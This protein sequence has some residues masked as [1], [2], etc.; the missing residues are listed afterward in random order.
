MGLD[1]GQERKREGSKGQ[2][3]RFA[4]KI[5]VG[6]WVLATTERGSRMFQMSFDPPG[7][8]GQTKP[9]ITLYSG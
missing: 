9:N 3:R 5:N 7:G 6:A 8:K 2:E 4:E 1:G